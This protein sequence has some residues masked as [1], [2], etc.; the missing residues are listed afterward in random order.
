M[1]DTGD[2]AVYFGKISA[3]DIWKF[4]AEYLGSSSEHSELVQLYKQFEGDMKLVRFFH[5]N[6][7]VFSGISF[8]CTAD[9]LNQADNSFVPMAP[10]Q[11]FNH[12]VCSDSRLDSHRFM[13]IIRE[14][15]AQG[16]NLSSTQ[17][18]SM[19]VSLIVYAKLI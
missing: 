6:P 16:K 4:E 19:L 1:T 9:C 18:P 11:V 2:L 15:I 5:C 13:D 12:M 3:E 10:E 14:E 17:K 7:V 8:G